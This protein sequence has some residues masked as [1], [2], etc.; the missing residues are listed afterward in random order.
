MKIAIRIFTLLSLLAGLAAFPA[1]AR[2]ESIETFTTCLD[3]STAECNA[4][5][6]LYISTQGQD[7]WR[8]MTGWAFD[9][10]AANWHGVTIDYGHV[11]ALDLRGN[12][13]SG[14]IPAS[15]GNLTYLQMLDL[16]NN[17][18]TGDLPTTIASLTH[19]WYLDLSSDSDPLTGL[20]GS[21]PANIGN[22]TLLEELRLYD[23]HLTGIIP[24]SI[25]N[26]THLTHLLLQGNDLYGPIPTTIS[27][28]TSLEYMDVGYNMLSGHIPGELGLLPNLKELKL[29]YNQ[30]DGE[31]PE[32]LMD[33]P[34]VVLYLDYNHLYVP[35]NYPD[36]ADPFQT[37]LSGLDDDWQYSQTP[38]NRIF[39]PV[40]KR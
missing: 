22:L 3:I 37:W 19:L 40:V 26:L 39:L 13:L 8:N 34:L 28:C 14:P 5:I 36:P 20:S 16:S 27:G 25:G 33:L 29:D 11:I 38:L 12:N 1:R 4:L 31:I 2:A 30:F 35:P 21:I 9:P 18:L 10:Y 32:S 23:N 24:T 6:D 15:I 7:E 17:P